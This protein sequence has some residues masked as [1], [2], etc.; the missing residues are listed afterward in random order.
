MPVL[1]LVSL[2]TFFEETDGQG[3]GPNGT[4]GVSTGAEWETEESGGTAFQMPHVPSSLDVSGIQIEEVTPD[5]PKRRVFETQA[6]EQTLSNTQF[7][8]QSYLTGRGSALADGVTATATALSRMLQNC[9]GGVSLT[10][11]RTATGGGHTTTVV[12]VNSAVTWEVGDIVAWEDADGLLHPRV[13]TAIAGLA[14]TLEPALPVAPSDDDLI[15]GG[16]TLY[17]DE[18]VIT[19]TASNTGSTLSACIQ[20]GSNGSAG[21][22]LNMCKAQLGA[23]NFARNAFPT[24]DFS[25][26]SGRHTDPSDGP[27]PD[28]PTASFPSPQLI[29]PDTSI[30][31]GDTGTSALGTVCNG[32]VSVDPGVPVVP[33]ECMADNLGTTEGY[34]L[35]STAPADTLIEVDLFPFDEQWYADKA[36]GTN[37][38]IAVI[39]NATSGNCFAFFAENCEIQPVTPGTGDFTSVS[40]R[41]RAV[42]HDPATATTAIQR[43]KFKI[44]LG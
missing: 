7:P 35:Y 37:K 32:T 29:G 9:L 5:S 15:R 33:L 28:L 12:N 42:E 20:K 1:N 16:A 26:S 19:D 13:I 2:L 17:I 39:K 14:V 4:S 18:D 8:F 10:A 11:T 21:W 23:V 30:I 44:F 6:A 41:L 40:P 24:L 34:G 22:E 27:D 43:S 36:A 31:I 3:I 38:R 25:V